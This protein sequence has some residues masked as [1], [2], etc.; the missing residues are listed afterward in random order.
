MSTLTQQLGVEREA[1]NES[2]AALAASK[3]E[4][5]DVVA[6]LQVRSF[7]RR[8]QSSTTSSHLLSLLLS[9]FS[10]SFSLISSLTF[11]LT[12]SLHAG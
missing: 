9:H 11:S 6:R 12:F 7:Y 5:R 2:R 3:E 1:I 10:L 8:P 4:M